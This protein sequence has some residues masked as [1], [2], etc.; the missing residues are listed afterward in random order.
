[1]HAQTE[2]AILTL[3]RDRRGSVVRH[4][5]RTS[6]SRR[7]GATRVPSC[8]APAPQFLAHSYP[9]RSSRRAASC[10]C[11]GAALC[12]AATREQC[13]LII[14]PACVYMRGRVA[15]ARGYSA[16]RFGLLTCRRER[17]LIFGERM[18]R[19]FTRWRFYAFPNIRLDDF[20]A[21]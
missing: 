4:R 15:C 3:G 16:A 18:W 17:E 8:R 14:H 2:R 13:D 20:D 19:P 6:S 7:S 11:R 12:D 5:R 10:A 1:M 9:A 21:L